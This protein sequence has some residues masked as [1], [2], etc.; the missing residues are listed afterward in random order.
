M[1]RPPPYLINFWGVF[2][3]DLFWTKEASIEKVGVRDIYALEFRLFQDSIA[4]SLFYMF[5]VFVFMVHG[6]LGWNLRRLSSIRSST[7]SST[8]P[9]SR[10]ALP[11][12]R[13][14][15]L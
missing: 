13:V 2:E 10:G 14:D 15:F 5:A 9:T 12:H 7:P 8:T 11:S 3:L 1:I 4:L 6:C